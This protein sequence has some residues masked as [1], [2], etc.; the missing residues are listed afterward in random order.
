MVRVLA[1]VP[2]IGSPVRLDGEREDSDLPPP[3]LG[4]HTAEVLAALGVPTKE[5]ERL[6]AANVLG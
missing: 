3:S 1:G 4:Q 6:S 5:V 2:L